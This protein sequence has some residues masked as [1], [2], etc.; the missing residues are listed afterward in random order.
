MISSKC[1]F[2]FVQSKTEYTIR[3]PSKSLGFQYNFSSP[4]LAI[5]TENS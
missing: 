2:K 4:G 1:G 5:S 3:I